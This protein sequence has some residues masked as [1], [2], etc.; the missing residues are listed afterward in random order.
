V[1]NVPTTEATASE[2]V[3]MAQSLIA[4]LG[5]LK[6]RRPGREIALAFTHAEES[7]M[8]LERIAPTV[9]AEEPAETGPGD[10]TPT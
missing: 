1:S 2:A 4:Y 3:Q 6:V 9:A 10:Q 5:V 7:L 8:W